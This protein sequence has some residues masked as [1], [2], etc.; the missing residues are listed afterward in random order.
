MNIKWLCLIALLLSPYAFKVSACE[1]KVGIR[2]MPP[3]SYQNSFSQWVGSDIDLFTKLSNKLDCKVEFI[4][5]TFDEGL[6][7]LKDGK[8]DAMSQLSKLPDRDSSIYFIGPVRDEKFTLMTHERVNEQI[9]ELKAISQLPYL[10]AKRKGTYLGNEFEAL[11]QQDREFANKFIEI[12]NYQPRIDLVLKGRVVGFFEETNFKNFQQ[13][14]LK[15]FQSLKQHPLEVATGDVYLG[16]SKKTLSE[17]Q[18]NLLN[19]Y[20]FQ[21]YH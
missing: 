13:V 11:Y 16:F 19:Q 9:T 20:Y 2:D 18:F 5:I 15:K 12:D 17:V 1:I 21:R 8:I 7:L 6:K 14:N 10:F 3:Y 4:K